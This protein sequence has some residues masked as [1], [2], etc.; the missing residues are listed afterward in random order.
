MQDLSD[1]HKKYDKEQ[2]G[3][4]GKS[5]APLEEPFLD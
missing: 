1:S 3:T 5:N 2:A 4:K